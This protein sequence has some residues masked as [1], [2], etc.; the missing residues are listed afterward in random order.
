MRAVQTVSHRIQRSQAEA[1]LE[2]A[3]LQLYSSEPLRIEAESD[4]QTYWYS[5]QVESHMVICASSVHGSSLTTFDG[6]VAL[7]MHHGIEYNWH[8]P[9]T[10]NLAQLLIMPIP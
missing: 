10:L 4:N 5:A 6:Q 1:T 8:A 7:Y 2:L 3:T 9:S